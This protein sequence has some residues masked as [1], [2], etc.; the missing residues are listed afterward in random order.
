MRA[1]EHKQIKASRYDAAPRSRWAALAALLSVAGFMAL[2]ATPASAAPQYPFLGTS[3]SPPYSFLETWTGAGTPAGTFHPGFEASDES[4]SPSDPHAGDLYVYDS[5][6][7]LIDVF[8]PGTTE[9]YVCQITGAGSASTSSSECDT[10]APGVPGGKLSGSS[11]NELIIALAVDPANGDLYVAKLFEPPRIYKFSPAG[12]YEGELALPS[13]VAAIFDLAVD[14]QSGDLLASYRTAAEEFPLALFSTTTGEYLESWDGSAAVNPPGTPTGIIGGPEANEVLVDQSSGDVYVTAGTRGLQIFGPEGHYLDTIP[15]ALPGH[16]PGS[17]VFQNTQIDQVTHR[18][19]VGGNILLDTPV[20]VPDTLAMEPTPHAFNATLNATVNPDGLPLTDC[21]FE[22]TT[23]A[24]F[25]AN[26]FEAAK[27]VPCAETPAQ[28]G[29]G[30]SPVPVHA[31]IGCPDPEIEAS[32]GKCLQPESL[33]QFR[34]VAANANESPNPT[35]YGS[36]SDPQQLETLPIPTIDSGAAATPTPTSADLSFEVNPKGHDTT[37]VVEWGQTEEPDNPAVSYQHTEPCSPE[38]LGSGFA[39]VSTT[40]HLEGL[41]AGAS[42]HWRVVVSS[43][44]AT[45]HGPDHTFVYLRPQAEEVQQSCENEALRTENASLSLPDCRAY[46]LVTPATRNGSAIGLGLFINR[47][48]LSLSGER[49]VGMSLTAFGG[50]GSSNG[51]RDGIEGDPYSFD[52]TPGGWFTTPLAP[53]ASLISANTPQAVSLANGAFVFFGPSAP[54]AQDD[55]Y[56]RAPAGA[57]RD[58]GPLTPPESGPTTEQLG[59]GARFSPDGSHVLWGATPRRGTPLTFEYAES[60]P[61]PILVGVSGGPGS[62]D[63]ISLCGVG[64]DSISADNQTVYFTAGKCNAGGSGVNAG[65]KVP[66]NRLYARIDG[67]GPGAETVLISA[68]SPTGCGAQ[69]Q[70]S[71]PADAEFQAAS[72]DGSLVYFTSEQRLLD[73]ASEG[74]KNL[75]L[76]D[77]SRPEGERL[78]D[79]SAGD[80]SGKGPGFQAVLGVSSLGLGSDNPVVS[81]RLYFLATGVLAANPGAAF[82]RETGRPQ[83][84]AAGAPNLYVYERDA[85]HPAG[86]M[87][88]I[89]TLPGSFVTNVRNSGQQNNYDDVTADGRYLVFTSQRPL[90]P[91]DSGPE[92]HGLRGRSGIYRY[93]AETGQLTRISVGERGFNDNGDSEL[94]QAELPIGNSISD[95][96]SRVF[97]Q[98]PAGLVPGALDMVQ[99]GT[100]LDGR[101]L[102]AQNVYE[103]HQGQVRLI[104]DGADTATVGAYGASV[105]ELIG[106]S[107]SGRD[108][109]FTTAD[110]L[111]PADTSTQVDIYDAREGGGFPR[112]AAEEPCL[113]SDACHTGATEEGANPSPGSGTFNG[114]EEGAN[115]PQKPPKHH[116]KKH[117]GKKKPHKHHKRADSNHGGGK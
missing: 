19:Y 96:G 56:L 31:D 6:H 16:R 106:A 22:Y 54:G 66:A 18:I 111:A 62:T 25:K 45:V 86:Q 113:T 8:E 17:L 53:P 13:S 116:K 57:I 52:R 71:P 37:C 76:Y 41:T 50:A 73:S 32:E 51:T 39:D 93:D 65:K 79:V 43:V 2:T 97:F 55:V 10:S 5:E 47:T 115:H 58:L 100:A 33:Y 117:H 88:F 105:V 68:P 14:G 9:H 38:D 26:Y 42:Y 30:S 80:T 74:S 83:T 94:A 60:F 64:A 34:L 102:Y 12:A 61:E 35:S 107:A 109:F 27:T 90:T 28:I 67:E 36:Y 29:E 63:L 108:V 44:A 49:V 114:P 89:A 20:L 1:T 15:A 70:E 98:S 81:S 112:P 46:E 3:T 11:S 91:D 59:I 82:D 69:C 104:S 92:G 85:A 103:W 48:L 23:E 40:L 101:P 75:Y 24:E 4:T 95:D 77:F 7:F 87:T 110:P 72:A 99:T 21:R 78:I 84:A